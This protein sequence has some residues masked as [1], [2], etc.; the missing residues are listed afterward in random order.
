MP[1]GT[2]G[3]DTKDEK[4]ADEQ[5]AQHRA[6]TRAGEA[7]ARARVPPMGP[8]P[9]HYYH[10]RLLLLLRCTGLSRKFGHL[11]GRAVAGRAVGLLLEILLAGEALVGIAGRVTC[12]WHDVAVYGAQLTVGRWRFF[13]VLVGGLTVVGHYRGLVNACGDVTRM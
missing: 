13:V 9:M 2:K 1:R 11:L 3:D 4:D 6:G 7:V 5:E 12:E 10:P 8:V